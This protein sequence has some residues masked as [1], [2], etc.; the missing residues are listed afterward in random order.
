[1]AGLWKATKYYVPNVSTGA[2][3]SIMIKNG[4]NTTER[5]A[6]T[7]TAVGI[8]PE[9]SA[10]QRRRGGK[11]AATNVTS[12]QSAVNDALQDVDHINVP[13]PFDI[14]NE[15]QL[16]LVEGDFVQ[17][18]TERQDGWSFGSKVSALLQKIFKACRFNF[19]INKG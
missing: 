14:L 12:R 13:I 8:I 19:F 16:V 15:P 18:T 11:P 3:S 7:G 17:V 1:M 10:K 9:Q 4:T 6:R 2:G 5:E